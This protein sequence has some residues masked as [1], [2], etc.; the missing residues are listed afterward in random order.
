MTKPQPRPRSTETRRV[1]M[2]IDPGIAPLD[3]A[4][5]L[6]GLRRHHFLKG[7][8]CYDLVTVGPIGRSRRLAH[9]HHPSS[10]HADGGAEAADR[11]ADDRRRRGRGGRYHA[12]DRRRLRHAGPQARRLVRL[13]RRLRARRRRARSTAS[14]SRP[15]GPSPS[16]WPRNSRR[17]GGRSIRSSCAT[18]ASIPRRASPPGSTSRRRSWPMTM[19]GISPQRGPV[20]GAVLAALGRAGT[21][22]A[23]I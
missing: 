17:Q 11:H 22:P 3:V 7:R 20:S 1:A 10:H 19:A 16:S 6:A 13:H 4:G 9:R 14:G 23:R 8:Q 2:L 15:T 18:E 21:V 5:P 12:A